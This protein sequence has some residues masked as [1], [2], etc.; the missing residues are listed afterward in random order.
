[1]K[2]SPGYRKSNEMSSLI[3][4][5]TFHGTFPRY[6]SHLNRSYAFC[7]LS[8]HPKLHLLFH[9]AIGLSNLSSVS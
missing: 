5:L 8:E 7:L 9:I 1:M 6:L 3:P 4:E 2:L